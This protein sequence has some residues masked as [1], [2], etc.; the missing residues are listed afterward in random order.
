MYRRASTDFLLDDPTPFFSLS[1]F[2]F[3]ALDHQER[4][5]G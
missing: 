4:P 5:I 3:F 2:L 1:S